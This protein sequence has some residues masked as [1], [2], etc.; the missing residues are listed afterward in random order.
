MQRPT[1]IDRQTQTDRQIERQADRQTN[2]QTDKQTNT[3][4]DREDTE[5]D[6]GSGTK[7]GR[8]AD[9]HT[10]ISYVVAIKV[11]RDLVP[12]LRYYKI[13]WQAFLLRDVH[14][15]EVAQ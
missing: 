5:R 6:R 4:T 3:W 1:Q 11:L 7:E 14:P 13:H 2:R 8:N 12:S 15:T 9:M 10:R